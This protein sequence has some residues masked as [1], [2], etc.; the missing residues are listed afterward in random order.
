MLKQK[1]SSNPQPTTQSNSK[2]EMKD[3][4][5]LIECDCDA[6]FYG[7]VLEEKKTKKCK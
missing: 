2:K 3:N 6:L 5:P 1:G 4:I 7:C